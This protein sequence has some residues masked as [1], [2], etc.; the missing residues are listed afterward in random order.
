MASQCDDQ[1]AQ[2][3]DQQ[4]ADREYP[5]WTFCL[6]TTNRRIRE[7]R[8]DGSLTFVLGFLERVEDE[9]HRSALPLSA[10]TRLRE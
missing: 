3:H 8:T 5:P 2:V 10:A 6:R 7:R 9:A 1:H 4:R